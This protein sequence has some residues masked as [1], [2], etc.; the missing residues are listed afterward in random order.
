[1]NS[2]DDSR[3]INDL[4]SVDKT[5]AT[6]VFSE[7]KPE[8]HAQRPSEASHSTGPEDVV[9][10]APV[11]AEPGAGADSPD[12]E[13]PDI[14]SIVMAMDQALEDEPAEAL[15]PALPIGGGQTRVPAH[16][17]KLADRARD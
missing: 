7:Q 8:I 14:V 10:A 17:E 16:L 4:P 3:Q 6:A 9:P 11:S 15:S 5:R 1:M 13:L 2:E 12:G